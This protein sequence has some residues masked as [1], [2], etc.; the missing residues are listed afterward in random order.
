MRVYSSAAATPL[1]GWKGVSRESW[2]T[3]ATIPDTHLGQAAKIHAKVHP[4]AEVVESIARDSKPVVMRIL[5]LA[6]PVELR[7][8]EVAL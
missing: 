8:G 5:N 3:D 4:T 6:A 7:L 1:V 2:M